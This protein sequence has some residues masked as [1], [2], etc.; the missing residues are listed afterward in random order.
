MGMY[1]D[2][3]EIITGDMPTPVKYY[4]P[5]IRHAYKEVES[6]AKDELLGGLPEEMRAYY[7][8]VLQDTE[9]EAVL[10]LY[11]KAADKLSALVKCIEERSMGNQDFLKA[12]ETTLQSIL[13]MK[14]PE[15]NFFVEHFIQAYGLT[16]D[17]SK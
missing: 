15:V 17:E 7:E 3:T 11:V 8:P 13:D 16:L 5:L 2:A 14:L 12:E 1:H 6:V 10:W 4:N 9:K